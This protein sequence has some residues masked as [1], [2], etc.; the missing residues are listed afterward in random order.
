MRIE[1][2]GLIGNTM[3]AALVSTTGS[4]DWLCLPNFDGG[5]CFA[6]LLG[7]VDNGHWKI[8]PTSTTCTAHRH[9]RPGTAIL[10]TVFE[11]PQFS[12]TCIDFMPLPDSEGSRVDV[13]RMVRCDRGTV[14]MD[15]CLVVRFDYGH[16]V[17]W[18]QK[19][20]GG[21][22]AIAGP[23]ALRVQSDAPLHGKDLTTRAE[24]T[25]ETG[26]CRAFCLSWFSSHLPAPP[27]IDAHQALRDTE[28]WWQRWSA[29]AHEVAV[30]KEPVLRSLIT[31]KAMTYGPTGA[32]V[33]APTTS[34][35]EKIGGSRNWDYR[36]CW[37]RDSTLT[38]YAFL[39]SGF[40]EEA[41][42]W[43]RWLL[44]AAA[45]EPSKLQIMY[46]L[47]GERRLTEMSLPW[48]AGYEDSKP[49]QIGNRAHRQLQ[50]DVYGEL[51][52]T[53]HVARKFKLEALEEA[54]MLQR[55]LIDYVAEMWEQP[56]Y[57][58]WEIRGPARHF[59]HS[60]VMSWVAIDRAVK[61]AENFGLSGPLESWRRLRAR[62]HASICEH[63]YSPRKGCF[64]QIYGGEQVD[65]SLLL[66]GQ[67]GFVAADDPR[68]LGTVAAIERELMV[69]GLVLR[70]RTEQTDDGLEP[71]KCAFLACSF[72][73]VD[74]YTLIGRHDDALRLF[75]HL[76]SL[77]N[78]LGLLA[79]EYDPVAQRQL[80]NFPQAFSHIALVNT[81]H[82]LMRSRH[83]PA[84]DRKQGCEP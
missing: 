21:V 50:L 59:T 79:E 34:L 54:W 9:Y 71:G 25:L 75:D 17:P 28:A 16:I 19:C 48:L 66:L 84:R 33:A 67:L 70:Y 31:L 20:P 3:S 18:V 43:R 14:D 37:I 11:S 41:K 24:F 82:N 57:G 69:D 15:F 42:Q 56:D 77:R 51:M 73:L 27:P 36:Y 64:T 53:L 49:V 4:I 47:R 68:F 45:G 76:L 40:V 2:Y 74:A 44:R 13:V 55:A 58:I 5:A 12:V 26:Q 46:G 60:K 29:Q 35:P 78:D 81:A 30:W 83:A 6:A 10:E 23:D 72:W 39:I 80:G 61:S 1:D 52:D 63:G 38:L 7:T 65:A 22:V 62:M 8:A 32:I